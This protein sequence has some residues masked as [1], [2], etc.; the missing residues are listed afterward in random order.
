MAMA[1]VKFQVV[2]EEDNLIKLESL[3]YNGSLLFWKNMLSYLNEKRRKK[4]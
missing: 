4:C 1:V 2:I 3:S